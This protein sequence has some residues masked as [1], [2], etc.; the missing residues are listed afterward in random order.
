MPG[1]GASGE[2]DDLRGFYDAVAEVLRQLRPGEVASYG[3]VAEQA[4]FPGAARAVGALLAASDGSFAWWR[5][6]TASGRLVPG[7]EAEQARLLRLEGVAIVGGRVPVRRE[8]HVRRGHEAAG[9]GRLPAPVSP[10]DAV[11]P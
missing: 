1:R 2:R 5:V 7:H 8:A 6:V 9:Q 3:D 10:Q 4:G 11:R